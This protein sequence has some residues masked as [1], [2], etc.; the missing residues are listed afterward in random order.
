MF[1]LE[2]NWKNKTFK[3]FNVGKSTPF[4]NLYFKLFQNLFKYLMY[5]SSIKEI[6]ALNIIAQLS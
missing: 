4:K 6:V 3:K 2:I 5:L 1:D